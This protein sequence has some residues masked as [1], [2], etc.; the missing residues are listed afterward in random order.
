MT[1]SVDQFVARI[2]D[3]PTR[4][5]LAT[6]GGGSRAISAILEVPGG[7][8]TLLEAI[9]PYSDG[10]MIHWL[11]GRPDQACSNPT[12]RAMAMA[13]FR[14][15][16]RYDP[17][18]HPV[19]GIACTASLI[20]DRPKK[21]PHRA[22]VAIQTASLTATRSLELEKG[23]RSRVQ[24]EHLITRL[25][26]NAVAESCGLEDRLDLELLD[27]ECVETSDVVAP[28]PWQD[29]LLERVEAVAHSGPPQRVG[30]PGRAIFPGAF[31]PM[32]VGH[33]RMAETAREAFGLAVEYELTILNVD[34]PPLD[35]FEINRRTDQF[36]PE[37]TLWLTRAGTFVKKSELFAGA[38]FLVGAD[39]LRRVADPRYYGGNEAACRAAIEQIIA[40]GC[41][42]LVFG[43]DLG[44]GFVRLADLEL[45][46]MLREV[47]REI[48][49]SEFREDV[50]S[51]A[52]RRAQDL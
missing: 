11:G 51:T 9:V 24:E 42:F 22:H 39:T 52:L 6:A 41:H 48:P 15:A 25:I 13:A 43:R 45:P 37:D 34:K 36:E 7:T 10:A 4:I 20:S 1:A 14:Q 40:R 3:S 47:C 35:Y 23:R 18:D 26:L 31:N 27:E 33:R 8:R 12:A 29:L 32:H 17:S 50:S 30:E 44:T 16:C 19:A 28:Q 38:T 46:E 21:G 2:H 49:A 5:V